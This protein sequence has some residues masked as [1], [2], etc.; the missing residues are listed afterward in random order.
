LITL[1]EEALLDERERSV[2][3]EL[4][5]ARRT[6]SS[7]DIPPRKWT[8]APPSHTEATDPRQST[9]EVAAH[10]LTFAAWAESSNVSSSTVE[11]LTFELSR[12]AVEYVHAPLLPLFRDLVMLRDNS[13]SLLRGH[14]SPHQA[15]ELFFLTGTTCVLLAHASQNLG[16]CGAA[17]AQVRTAWTC[18]EQADHDGLRGW[19]RGT[20]ALIAEW[21]NQQRRALEYAQ[22]GQRYAITADSRIRLAAIEARAAAW[23]GDR[24]RAISALDTVRRIRES[25]AQFD[26]LDQFGGVLSFPLPKQLYY[27]GTT[28]VLLD[29]ADHAQQHALDAIALYESGPE[30]ARSYGDESLA[31]LDLT[32][33]RVAL[34]DLDGAQ[35]AIA[36]V[37]SLP[38]EL[39][40]RQLGVGLA[41]VRSALGAPGFARSA[42]ACSLAAAL[43]EF[44]ASK[45]APSLGSG[46]DHQNRSG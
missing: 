26:E 38:I 29:E 41:R 44:R 45:T 28:Y 13:F 14:Q 16:D 35:E 42:L 15:R 43:D 4:C 3:R 31:R 11:H 37:L 23:V 12:I 2:L 10:S 36:P 9:T 40:I 5:A 18:A 20:A 25:P 32:S 46:S 27:T 1:D 21:S 8:R 33:A 39:R 17:M 22:E 34:G 7:L 19:S 6:S 24:G 30:T